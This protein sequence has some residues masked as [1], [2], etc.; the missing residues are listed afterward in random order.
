MSEHATNENVL[1]FRRTLRS[2]TAIATV[3]LGCIGPALGEESIDNSLS[4][5]TPVSSDELGA[6]RG[7]FAIGSVNVSF[8]FSLSTSISGGTLGQGVT[9]TTNFTVSTPGNLQN[10]GTTI[11]SAVQQNLEKAGLVDDGNPA[12]PTLGEKIA[13]T[14]DAALTKTLP[15][16]VG[17]LSPAAG[18]NGASA[19]SASAPTV[20]NTAPLSSAA[21]DL[22]NVPT[23]DAP[24]LPTVAST[25][26]SLPATNA[27][28]VDTS[29]L[30]SGS[31]EPAKNS[32]S[33]APSGVPLGD[34]P[35]APSVI[36]PTVQLFTA[37]VDNG[38]G[39]VSLSAGGTSLFLQTL[40]G[41]LALIQNTENDVQ[42]K[43][44]LS[45]NYIIENYHDIADMAGLHQ[46][47]TDLAHQLIALQG[48]GHQ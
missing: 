28:A 2:G 13:S 1:R 19:L 11:T 6:E 42:I 39:S 20:A 14:V 26:P 41:Q 25:A 9:V 32:A 4:G 3:L 16:V 21:S 8:G 30:A 18:S 45:A 44:S 10:L 5:L 24:A 33:D 40:Q 12:T 46:Q 31:I 35:P 22:T 43:S 7:G 17:A 36:V 34:R 48:L 23:V 47:I 27:P 37:Q 38:N 29:T 15:N